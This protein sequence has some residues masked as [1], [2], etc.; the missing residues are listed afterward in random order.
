MENATK[1]EENKCFCL[2]DCSVAKYPYSTEPLKL[3]DICIIGKYFDKYN[4]YLD[5]VGRFMTKEVDWYDMLSRDVLEANP[6]TLGT[7]F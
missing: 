3:E 4:G 6:S 1:M 5:Q 7:I 2:S